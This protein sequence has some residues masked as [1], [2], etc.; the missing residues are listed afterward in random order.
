MKASGHRHLRR[1]GHPDQTDGSG[2]GTCTVIVEGR[3]CTSRR[4]P[5]ALAAALKA[6]NAAWSSTAATAS[7]PLRSQ[8]QRRDPGYHSQRRPVKIGESAGDGWYKITFA[9]AEAS[10]TTGYMKGEFLANQ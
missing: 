6:G 8:H 1:S 3:Q 7:G 4:F 9:A 10:L 5:P 2:K